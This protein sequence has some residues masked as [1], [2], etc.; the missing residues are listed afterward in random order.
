MSEQ[1]TNTE[2]TIILVHGAWANS[3]SW[4]KVIP[5]LQEKNLN[6]VAV[7]LPLS[8]LVDDAA[9]V[10]RAIAAAGGEVILVGHSW[11]GTVI[12]QAG[13]D[14]KVSA[15]VYVAAFAPSKNQ[16]VNELFKDYPQPEW[17][18]G[19]RVDSGGFATLSPETVRD[20]FAQDLTA[21]ETQI[22]AVTQGP[23]AAK[24]NDEKATETAWSVKPSW[25]IVAE[26]DRIINPDLERAM[27]EKLNAKT[28]TL[29]TSHVAMLAKPKEVADVIIA[30]ATYENQS[31]Q[32]A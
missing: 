12:T 3:S 20:F 15:L 23:L 28:T 21:A 19:L 29:P 8:S 27:A 30:A 24:A 7:H 18:G 17:L 2:K 26:N 5:I 9:T 11:G 31:S 6:V 13:N 25:Y 10:K 14:E 4:D 16:S 22:M 32:A 1:Q